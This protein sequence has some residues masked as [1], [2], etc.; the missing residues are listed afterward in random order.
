MSLLLEC[1]TISNYHSF[2]TC[3]EYCTCFMIMCTCDTI[4]Q[5]LLIS[6][7]LISWVPHLIYMYKLHVHVQITCMSIY[8][9]CLIISDILIGLLRLRKC[10]KDVYRAELQ[11]GVS[12]VRELHVYPYWNWNLL[13]F[14]KFKV[15]IMSNKYSLE[16]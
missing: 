12:I 11:G 16:I 10:S 5:F 13:K 8:N 6:R 14:Q 3:L 4:A 7:N 15:V 1:D 2:F 9:F